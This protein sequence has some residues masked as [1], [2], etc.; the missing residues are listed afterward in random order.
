[1][2]ECTLSTRAQNALNNLGYTGP[3]DNESIKRMLLKRELC[4]I[5]A[6]CCGDKT[7]AGIETAL[8][9][10]VGSL[11]R[12]AVER[13]KNPWRFDPHTGAPFQRKEA[14]KP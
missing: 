6:Y 2:S 14:Q 10:P 1:M 13:S 5:G 9:L 4:L 3:W 12:K 8:G 7:I 11:G